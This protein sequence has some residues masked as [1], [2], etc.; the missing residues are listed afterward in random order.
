MES[1]F[2]NYGKYESRTSKSFDFAK[3]FC[4]E[5]DKT[6]RSFD[7]TKQI[8]FLISELV[9]FRNSKVDEKM[10]PTVNRIRPK[11]F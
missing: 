7:V 10:R 8:I 3:I 9:Q 1:I 6:G 4:T 5:K 2:R 11:L